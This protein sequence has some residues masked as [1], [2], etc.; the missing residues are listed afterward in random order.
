MVSIV[1]LSGNEN[2]KG[3]RALFFLEGSKQSVIGLALDRAVGIDNPI[4]K[5]ELRQLERLLEY[6]SFG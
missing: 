3:P 4:R 5:N 1:V 6:Q 2:I